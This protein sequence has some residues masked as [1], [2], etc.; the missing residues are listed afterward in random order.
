M[1][2]QV[3]VNVASQSTDFFDGTFGKELEL[4]G[5]GGSHPGT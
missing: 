5:I 4:S 1:D 2:S 3:I